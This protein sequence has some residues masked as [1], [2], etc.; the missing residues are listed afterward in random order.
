M[1]KDRHSITVQYYYT[2]TCSGSRSDA[3]HSPQSLCCRAPADFPP[4]RDLI[5]ALVSS[6]VR[7]PASTTS[8][9]FSAHH[10]T[11]AY[12][13]QVDS[14]RY[15][16]LIL[17][18]LREERSAV[19]VTVRSRTIRN[20]VLVSFRSAVFRSTHSRLSLRQL[21]FTCRSRRRY[22]S[23]ACCCSFHAI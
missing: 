23:S 4:L 8:S 19:K 21:R 5:T 17:V 14:A 12:L 16:A 3:R 7:A 10:P 18:F 1:W 6:D 20:S 13:G 11:E 22:R 15:P 2:I 9:S